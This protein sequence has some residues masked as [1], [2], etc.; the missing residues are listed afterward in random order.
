MA[1]V[2]LTSAATYPTNEDGWLKTVTVGAALEYL[3]FLVVPLFVLLGYYVRVMRE[4]IDGVDEPPTYADPGELAADGGKAALVLL[5]YLLVP[6][7]VFWVL[8][9]TTVVGALSGNVGLGSAIVAILVGLLIALAVLALF[10]Y[11]GAAGLAAFASTGSLG[12][13]FSPSIF[14]VLVSRA[15]FK[16]WVFV[17]IVSTGAGLIL[18][19]I[20]AIPV[21][22]LVLVV[23]A[24]MKVKYVG[25]VYAR[26]WA[27]AYAAAKGITPSAAT[28]AAPSTD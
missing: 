18:S 19:V 22:N 15:Y 21:L 10:T 8:V 13:A 16:A 20:G 1:T 17:W 7:V 12:A 26:L 4:T 23:L 2:E 6:T 27:Q 28:S 24:P 14:G 9:G 5:A 3:S 11:V 25:T